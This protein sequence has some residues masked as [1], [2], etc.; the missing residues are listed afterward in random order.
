MWRGCALL[1][2]LFFAMCAPAKDDDPPPFD[3]KRL[4]RAPCATRA[5]IADS[6]IRATTTMLS[7]VPMGKGSRQ[8]IQAI[9]EELAVAAESVK[10]ARTACG[11]PNEEEASRSL[12]ATAG[13]VATIT[14]EVRAACKYAHKSR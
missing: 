11:S 1:L 5:D 10:M 6:L 3:L 14:E 7:S 2:L 8:D 4:E 12:I 9:R 13:R